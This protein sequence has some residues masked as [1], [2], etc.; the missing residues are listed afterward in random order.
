MP[1]PPIEDAL[2]IHTPALMALAGV[3][4]TGQGEMDGV[5]SIIVFVTRREAI[6]GP[7]PDTLS[8]HPVEIREVGDVRAL[9]K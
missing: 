5:P 1:D 6:G 3:I 9:G 2:R 7:I 4:G 8:G